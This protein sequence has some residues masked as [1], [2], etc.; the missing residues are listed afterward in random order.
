MAI[1]SRNQRSW[2]ITMTLPGN[3]S[4]ASS[5]ARSV[6]T[7]RSLDGSSSSSTLPPAMRVLARCRRPR[8]PPDNCP[9]ILFWSP[10]LKLEAAQVGARGHFELAHGQQVGAVGHRVEH[11]LVALER[12][13]RL[14]HVGQL[15]RLAQLHFARIGLLAAGQHAKQRGLARAV[16]A[17]DA[18]DSAGRHLEAEVVDQQAVAI[19]LADIVELDDFIA[20]AVAHRNEDFLGF[21]ALLVFIRG[22]LLEAGDTRLGLGLAALKGSG[23]PTPV[24]S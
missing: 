5:S 17:D 11:G 14:V 7:S 10:P 15:D 4:S 9:T 21:V 1:R 19:G 3:S 6:S 16:G 2:L 18:D 23:A 12:I 13:A 20:Q 8:S 24:P 22:Q